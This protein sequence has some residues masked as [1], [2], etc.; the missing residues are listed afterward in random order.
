VKYSDPG[1]PIDVGFALERAAVV[2][3]VRSKGLEIKPADQARIFERFYRAAETQ[4]LP[5]GTGLGLSIVKKIVEAHRG[6]VW[7]E[8]ESNYGTSFS[9]SLPIAVSR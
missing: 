3:R 5:S 2:L 4:H 9:L 1:S 8:G 6:R 7:A